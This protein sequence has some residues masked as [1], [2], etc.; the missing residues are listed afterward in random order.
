MVATP[1]LYTIPV[2][3][4]TE[5]AWRA[6]KYPDI[7]GFSALFMQQWSPSPLSQCGHSGQ[8]N[9]LARLLY[10]RHTFVLQ[11]LYDRVT[12][13]V[14]YPAYVIITRFSLSFKQITRRVQVLD[15]VSVLLLII[16]IIIKYK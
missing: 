12:R 4:E 9:T 13:I 2:F 11:K 8:S 6:W 5:E 7:K 3:L 14:N 1:A 16:I 10:I 15:F